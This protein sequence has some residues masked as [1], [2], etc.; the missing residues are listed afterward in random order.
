[1]L[2]ET[3][4]HGTAALSWAR[5]LSTAGLAVPHGLVSNGMLLSCRTQ[6]ISNVVYFAFFAHYYAWAQ[7]KNRKTKW[8]CDT[9]TFPICPKTWEKRNLTV[10]KAYLDISQAFWNSPASF[11][12]YSLENDKEN[13]LSESDTSLIK[14]FFTTGVP[15]GCNKNSDP[16]NSEPSIVLKKRFAFFRKKI[17]TVNLFQ[18]LSPNVLWSCNVHG[19]LPERSGIF[20]FS[21]LSLWRRS[22]SEKLK[23]FKIAADT[24]ITFAG[25]FFYRRKRR[26][27]HHNVCRSNWSQFCINWTRQW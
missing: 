5:L 23:R 8:R 6:C 10:T 25:E 4:K 1:M 11:D 16:E 15:N 27:S 26:H 3:I 2:F 22:N 20:T 13:D 19:Q 18:F 7:I 12:G 24:L 21:G 9:K 14:S 17:Y